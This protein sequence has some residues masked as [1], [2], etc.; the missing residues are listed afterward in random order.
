MYRSTHLR[1]PHLAIEPYVKSLC[2]LSGVAYW[3]GLRKA[4]SSCYDVY[5]KLLREADGRLMRA[6]CRTGMWRRKNACSACTYEL[7]GEQELRFKILVTMDG[8]DSLKRVLRRSLDTSYDDSD[9]EGPPTTMGTQLHDPRDVGEGVYIS[10]STV[11]AHEKPGGGDLREM[12]DD[13]NPCASRWKNMDAE[14]T[15][16][17]WGMFDESGV[18]VCLC[19][20]GFALVVLDMVRSGELYV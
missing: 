18:F 8:N 19:R 6:L 5:I 9:D 17:M 16:R 20:H 10:N 13:G 11:N 1:C 4:F 14:K 3:P 7:K 12:E 15:G 2:D